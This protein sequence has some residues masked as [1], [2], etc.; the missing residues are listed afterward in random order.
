MKPKV[1]VIIPSYNKS[2]YIAE[3]FD[4]LIGQDYNGWEA[5]V[6]DDGSTDNSVKIIQEYA[7]KDQRIR[8]YSRNREPKG[9]SVCR[10][11][12][13]E[14]SFGYYIVFLDADDLLTPKALK[15]RV[16]LMEKN[17]EI[18]FLVF[19]IGQFFYKIGD[20]AKVT[21]TKEDDNHLVK[22]LRCDLQ[23]SIPSPIWKKSFLYHIGL[24]DEAFPRL[25][26][27]E[28]HTRALLEENV[29]YRVVTQVEIDCYYR[30]DP[31]RR[32]SDTLLRTETAIKGFELFSNNMY[33]LVKTRL[34]N[35]KLINALKNVFYVAMYYVVKENLTLAN[36]IILIKK[37]TDFKSF[38]IMMSKQDKIRFYYVAIKSIIHISKRVNVL[39]EIFSR[40]LMKISGYNK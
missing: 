40:K 23:W 6:V 30:I 1:S 5:I 10:N 19:Q 7:K 16:D 31:L 37:I 15:Q 9:G 27:V 38:N 2:D 14:K 39:Q 25:Q 24:F 8:F 21:I 36:K 22:F 28:L 4:S 29:Q 34:D 32:V 20:C 13:I 12:G 33:Q 35:K 18:D 3:T 26:D 17:P 11:I